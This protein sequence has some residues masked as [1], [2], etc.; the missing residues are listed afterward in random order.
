ML[1]IFL[2]LIILIIQNSVG[3]LG[4][5]K[6]VLVLA[7]VVWEE[8]ESLPSAAESMPFQMEQ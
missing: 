7:I 1:P 8:R 4:V 3:K 5:F 2:D 6:L